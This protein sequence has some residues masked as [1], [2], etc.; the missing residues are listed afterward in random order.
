MK[1]LYTIL[2]SFAALLLPLGSVSPATATTV[3]STCYANVTLVGA[4]WTATGYTYRGR[5][6]VSDWSQTQGLTPS[7]AGQKC[8]IRVTAAYPQAGAGTPKPVSPLCFA[9][10]VLAI[11]RWWTPGAVKNSFGDVLY[12]SWNTSWGLYPTS[13]SGSVCDLTAR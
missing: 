3:T 1:K 6:I 4:Q 8:T 9:E 5:E 12:S 13:P 11:D 7:Y 2:L 10:A